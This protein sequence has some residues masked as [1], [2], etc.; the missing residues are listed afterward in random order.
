MGIYLALFLIIIMTYPVIK[1]NKN[2]YLIIN[3][4]CIFIVVALRNSSVGADTIPYKNFFESIN[5]QNL[6]SNFIKWLAHLHDQR[7]ETGFML[8][9]KILY[10]INLNFQYELII[11][12]LLIITCYVFFWVRLEVNY[13]WGFLTYLSLG[14]FANSMNLLRQSIAWA[15]LL[16]AFVYCI[17]KKHLNFYYL[18]C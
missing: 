7:F 16:V 18:L 15:L 8:Y 3:S 17:E 1:Y 5:L 11:T 9:N 14:F 10:S 12:S 13:F 4:I 6:P 2:L